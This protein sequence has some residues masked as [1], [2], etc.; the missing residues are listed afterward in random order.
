MDSS[1]TDVS[2]PKYSLRCVCIL[3]ANNNTDRRS[4]YWFC[5]ALLRF[6]CSS[7]TCRATLR[8]KHFFRHFFL[9]ISTRTFTMRLTGLR[10]A[11]FNRQWHF[12]C[13]PWA[14]W[15]PTWSCQPASWSNVAIL[16]TLT[17]SQKQESRRE[18]RSRRFGVTLG[19]R[20][21]LQKDQSICV[22]EMVV[23][24]SWG[25]KVNLS[26]QPGLFIFTR[27]FFSINIFT[28]PARQCVLHSDT[29]AWASTSWKHTEKHT[30]RPEFL[31]DCIIW[32]VS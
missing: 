17:T 7:V 15:W 19:E 23:F 27:A 18:N 2:K 24:S 25:T 12:T 16:L 5:R 26:Y 30:T 20:P 8:F 9:T 14:Y 21:S 3:N 13:N 6:A 32:P 11:L 31:N 10:E 4:K 22:K 29:A 28:W 1:V